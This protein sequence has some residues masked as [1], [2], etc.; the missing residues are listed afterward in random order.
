M[1]STSHSFISPYSSLSKSSGHSSSYYT[2]FNQQLHMQ[3]SGRGNI[4]ILSS[5]RSTD[6]LPEPTL[7]QKVCCCCCRK[8]PSHE[9]F[10]SSWVARPLPRVS[11]TYQKLDISDPKTH[12]VF[13]QLL[14]Q[15]NDIALREQGVYDTLPSLSNISKI[16]FDFG[17]SFV[18][19]FDPRTAT[20]ML[21]K[22][23]E[24]MD[25]KVFSGYPQGFSALSPEDQKKTAHEWVKKMGVSEKQLLIQ[26]LHHFDQ[27][28]A[29]YKYNKM[30]AA[31]LAT[32]FVPKLFDQ[33]TKN[34]ELDKQE[35][36]DK[37]A[38]LTLVIKDRSTVLPLLGDK[39]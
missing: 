15:V 29:N 12:Y 32:V 7:W 39:S 24:S 8:F 10:N 4:S 31:R 1:V 13:G 35:F 34:I 23:L 28:I 17:D 18:P 2:E 9:S 11:R 36:E 21:K 38:F 37:K 3:E 33:K 26:L 25:R 16:H 19:S 14:H 22:F 20:L 5:E 27:V 30:D 6:V